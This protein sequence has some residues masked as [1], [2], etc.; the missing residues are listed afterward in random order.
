MSSGL[1]FVDIETTGLDP[2]RHE[3]WEVGLIVDD[4]E[5]RWQLPIDID[6]ADPIALDIS[7]YHERRLRNV[8][9]EKGMTYRIDANGHLTER[10]VLDWAGE[11]A[12]LTSGRHLVGAVVSFDEERLRKLLLE[13]AVMPAWHYHLID[14][15][16]LMVGFLAARY[17]PVPLPWKS[18]QLSR[19]VGVNPDSFAAHTALGDARWAKACWE[20][21]THW[22]V[23]E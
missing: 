18:K 17:V 10:Q 16:A 22:P 7:G 20:A 12:A 23:P 4:V 21:V 1:A 19:L 3:P 15:E 13:Q 6:E 14:I 2:Y 8:D 5:Y 11:F 9:F